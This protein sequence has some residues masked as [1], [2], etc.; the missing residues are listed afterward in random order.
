MCTA[1]CA[2]VSQ[3]YSP[4]TEVGS[5]ECRLDESGPRESFLRGHKIRSKMRIQRKLSWANDSFI[6]GITGVT[7]IL[8]ERR[9]MNAQ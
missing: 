6:D 3:N 4:L 5:A 2:R 7:E 8:P 9:D 1:D